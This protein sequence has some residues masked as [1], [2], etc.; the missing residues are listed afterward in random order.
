VG[1]LVD[2]KLGRE[3]LQGGAILSE[4]RSSETLAARIAAGM[5]GVKM[6][7]AGGVVTPAIGRL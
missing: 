2:Q 5:P 3:A 4:R 7:A 6:R 1:A